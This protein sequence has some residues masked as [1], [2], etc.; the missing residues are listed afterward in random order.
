M[1]SKVNDIDD[2][3]VTPKLVAELGTSFDRYPHPIFSYFHH[4]DRHCSALQRFDV[5]LCGCDELIREAST[6]LLSKVRK[7]DIVFIQLVPQPPV[8]FHIGYLFDDTVRVDSILYDLIIIE[9][10]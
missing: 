5:K 3:E 1:L 9:I 8:R 7:L 2:M 4:L 10:R 6:K